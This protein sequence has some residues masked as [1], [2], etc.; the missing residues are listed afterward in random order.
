VI[1]ALAADPRAIERSGRV[2]VAADAALAYRITDVDGRQP[3][4]LTL[5]DV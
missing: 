1:A 2:V 3:K 5:A 4:P